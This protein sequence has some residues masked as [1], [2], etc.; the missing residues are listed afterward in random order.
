MKLSDKKYM[1]LALAEAQ[2]ALEIKEVPVGAVIVHNDR[3]IGSGYNLK[4]KTGDPTLH[5]EIIA[6]REA[7]KHLSDWRLNNCEL[8]VTLEPCPMCA[9]AMI[10]A[11]IK[12]LVF[13]APDKKAGAVRSLYNLLEDERFNHQIDVEHGLMEKESQQLLQKFFKMLRKGKDG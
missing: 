12:R 6:I 10:Q 8:Y 5:A 2:K 13:A 11:R 9:G 7:S 4:E 1:N 3:V